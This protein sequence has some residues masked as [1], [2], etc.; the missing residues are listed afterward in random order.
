MM[1]APMPRRDE[2]E[3][4]IRAIVLLLVVLGLPAAVPDSIRSSHS[5]HALFSPAG[6]VANPIIFLPLAMAALMA[7]LW[8]FHGR[9]PEMGSVVPRYAPPQDLSPMEAGVLVDGRLDPR[10]V[11]AGVVELAIRGYLSIEP[12]RDGAHSGS[13]H[14][15]YRFQNLHK[16]G[17]ATELADHDRFLMQHIF[18][19]GNE[20]LLSALR[21]GLNEYLSQFRDAVL[22]SLIAK[23]LYRLQP[24]I[25]RTL[26]LV[27]GGLLLIVI[28][29]LAQFLD[30]KLAESAVV[31][32]VS[33][34][35]AAGVVY[36]MGTRISWR[37]RAGQLALREVLGLQEFL[38]RV[39]KA[40]LRQLPP[41]T[42][43]KMLPYAMAL[44]VEGHWVGA[45]KGLVAPYPW[46]IQAAAAIAAASQ[47][48]DSSSGEILLM[49]LDSMTRIVLLSR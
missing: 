4:D 6:L 40:R 5:S 42:L 35:A 47:S 33:F 18:E 36:W 29:F 49:D 26:I 41:E 48:D 24:D 20:P 28:A 39:E 1:G 37:S 27:G 3:I 11:V 38:Q 23:K 8:Y 21:H 43:E 45:F 10:D 31:Y 32:A 46:Y 7:A 19:T 34:A 16:R 44:G 17:W 14:A 30:L 9:S 25:G 12:V 13:T 15:D 2:A 22:A